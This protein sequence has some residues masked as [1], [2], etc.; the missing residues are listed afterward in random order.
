MA[1]VTFLP[2]ISASR[3]CTIHNATNDL[4]WGNGIHAPGWGK[5]RLYYNPEERYPVGIHTLEEC[6]DWCFNDSYCGLARWYEQKTECHVFRFTPETRYEYEKLE[7]CITMSLYYQMHR[8]ES[9]DHCPHNAT[10]QISCT[11]F[12]GKG[13]QLSSFRTY[14]QGQ[15]NMTI[16]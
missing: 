10:H 16:L 6:K 15:E 7:S 12:Q 14:S 3:Y 5:P 9:K 1:I 4:L 13:D 8:F 2:S 11:S